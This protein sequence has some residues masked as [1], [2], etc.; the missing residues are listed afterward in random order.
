M[1]KR[2]ASKFKTKPR[3]ISS[4]FKKGTTDKWNLWKAKA[5]LPK[6]GQ[7]YAIGS[8]LT[9][10]L[11]AEFEGVGRV[12][13]D[14]TT[15]YA[16]E[17]MT[18]KKFFPQLKRII[19][20]PKGKQFLLRFMAKNTVKKIGTAAVLGGGWFS[21]ATSLVGAGLAVKDIMNIVKNWNP[22]EGEE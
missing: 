12:G 19:Q 9:G 20:S 5:G 21:L 6:L 7:R 22:E 1:S 15:G 17:K 2:W 4:L 11:G 14:I 10:A 16:A 18:V 8:I 3:V 13:V